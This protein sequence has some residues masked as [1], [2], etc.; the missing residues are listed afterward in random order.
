MKAT[1]HAA[2]NVAAFVPPENPAIK[3]EKNPNHQTV[4]T[5]LKTKHTTSG[6]TN[7]TV[8][9]GTADFTITV[10]NN[11][12]STLHSVKVADQLSPNCNRNIGNSRGRQV[13]DL[14]LHQA[15]RVEELHERRG[16][17]G[18][19]AQGH[20]G[21]GQGRRARRRQGQDD[22]DECGQ[23]HRLGIEVEL[24]GAA[25]VGSG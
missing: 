10:T 8:N 22:L 20:E 5:N 14:Q 16:C 25:Q 6:A 21:D 7:T 15:H 19:L 1:D 23:V 13:Q 3:I 4:T 18:A 2:I 12:K 24:A 11:G 9:Y 17:L